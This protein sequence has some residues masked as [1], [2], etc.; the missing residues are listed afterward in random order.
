[1]LLGWLLVL[2]TASL[3]CCLGCTGPDCTR[4]P[5]GQRCAGRNYNGRRCCTPEQPCGEGEGD[6]DGPGD[7]G[8]HDGHAGCRGDLQCGSN[9]CRKFGAYYH[10]KDD[11]CERPPGFQT[12][13]VVGSPWSSWSG[14]Q[15]PARPPWSGPQQPARPPWSS[16]SGPQQPAR[17]PWSPVS[18][19]RP[20]GGLGIPGLIDS[21]ALGIIGAIHPHGQH[22]GHSGHKEPH[23]GHFSLR[24]G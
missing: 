10:P 3:A 5:P 11:C 21:I 4:P 13:S 22:S 18:P 19:N 1:M 2:L 6:C 14:T 17:P 20:P 24:I 16:W 15:Q 12:P 9:N 7:G 8:D 23:G